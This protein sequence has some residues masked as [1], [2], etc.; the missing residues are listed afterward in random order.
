MYFLLPVP[1]R[2]NLSE[3]TFEVCL[4][5]QVYIPRSTHICRCGCFRACFAD[6]VAHL[7]ILNDTLGEVIHHCRGQWTTAKGDPLSPVKQSRIK[8]SSGSNTT[9]ICLNLVLCSS[10]AFCS[11]ID[12][13]FWC[14][15]D[16][17]HC[18]VP[19]LQAYKLSKDDTFDSSKTG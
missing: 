17:C 16:A 6:R 11:N 5:L 12:E 2:H 3:I 13:L 18:C 14:V 4:I 10:I 15:Y 19:K 9:Y 7:L 8:V 1:H